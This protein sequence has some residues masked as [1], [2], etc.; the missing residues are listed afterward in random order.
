MSCADTALALRCQTFIICFVIIA[1]RY[2]E[3]KT[4][5]SL[6]KGWPLILTVEAN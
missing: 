6:R 5:F 1:W 2:Q 4:G 3:F